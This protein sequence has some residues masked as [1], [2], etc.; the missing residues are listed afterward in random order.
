[1]LRLLGPDASADLLKEYET[2]EKTL[3]IPPETT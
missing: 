3:D 2:A 1:V